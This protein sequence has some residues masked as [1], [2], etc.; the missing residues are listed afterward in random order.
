MQKISSYLYPNRINVVADLATFPVRWNIVY[1]N[2]V[3]IY[4]G[5]D[6]LITIDFKNSEQKRIDLTGS[7]I[8][9]SVMDVN[10]QSVGV[11][12]VTLSTTT[13]GLGTVNIPP[14]ILENLEPQFLQFSIVKTNEDTTRTI[15]YAD[16]QFGALGNME[17]IGTVSPVDVPDRFITT[18]V[19]I[20]N[21]LTLPWTKTFYSDAVEI[22]KPN[23]LNDPATDVMSLEF[24]LS[25]LEGTVTV[26]YTTESVIGAGIKWND[27]DTFTVLPA[28]STLTNVY[29][30]AAGQYSREWTWLRVNYIRATN[31][32]GKIDKI[33]VKL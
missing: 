23:Q 26:Q 5:I 22:R 3:K 24:M 18:W 28:T 13:V 7:S 12:P 19:E 6:N 20:N 11:F 9:M 16:T 1:Q 31:N 15:F 10:G 14:S 8:E 2:R 29:T 25:G 32:T 21:T 17:L 27:L 33:I 30:S 4:K